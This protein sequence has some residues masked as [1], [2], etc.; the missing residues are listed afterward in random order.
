MWGGMCPRSAC[1]FEPPLGYAGLLRGPGQH[2]RIVRLIRRRDHLS[3]AVDTVR[4]AAGATRD[5]VYAEGYILGQLVP[6]LEGEHADALD[7][8]RRYKREIGLLGEE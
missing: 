3:N 4:E 7:E 1:A 5:R 8:L 2:E 6:F